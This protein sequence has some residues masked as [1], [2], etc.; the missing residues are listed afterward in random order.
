MF[1]SCIHLPMS[2]RG[3]PTLPG[4]RKVSE[5]LRKIR[6]WGRAPP[7][8]APEGEKEGV[9]E[10]VLIWVTTFSVAVAVLTAVVLVIAMVTSIVVDR[11]TSVTACVILLSFVA[12]LIVP[13]TS[14][15]GGEVEVEV[16]EGN[17]NLVDGCAG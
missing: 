15:S 14:S 5:G 4:S 16:E 12:V 13:Y 6:K 7:P 1:H 8:P 17:L 10:G 9:L 11:E 2:I 3:G